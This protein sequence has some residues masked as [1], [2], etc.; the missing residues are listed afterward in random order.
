MRDCDVLVVGGGGAGMAA[1]IEA[2]D[3]GASVIVL[4]AGRRPGGSTALSGGVF[5]A[6][7]T[8]IQRAAGIHDTVEA[9]YRYYMTF[10]R[11]NLEPWLIRRF[12]EESAPT[13]EWLIGLGADIPVEGLYISGVED[14]P[15]GHH[16]RGSG[17]ALFERLMGAASARGVEIHA[18]IRV[19]GLLAADGVVEGITAQ[20]AELRAGAIVLAT[21]G[22]GANRALLA[23]FNPDVA[24]QDERWSFYFGS[25]TSR[26]DGIA[27][28]RALGAEVVGRDRLLVN[29]SPGFS[30]D[31]ADFHPPWL[32]FVNRDGQRF[33]DETWPY[34]IAGHRIEEQPGRRCFAIL[35]EPTRAA[36]PARH[37]FADKL[38][39]G[40]FAYSCD[41][42]AEEAAKGRILRAD[43][44]EELAGKA[45]VDPLGLAG[46]VARYNA[47]VRA[48]GDGQY[49]K[50]GPLTTIETAPFYAIEVHA[51][52]FGATSAGVRIDP[53]ARV[54][55]AGGR[56]IAGLYAA[57]ETA[58][59]VLGERYVGGGN[60]I[61]NALIFG[62]IAGRAAAAFAAQPS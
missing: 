47:D 21:G 5:Y 10:N 28:A 42:L 55:G 6:A 59:G 40:D 53:D 24:A 34:C 2:A 56:A 37:P 33:M 3:A 19:D 35:D 4:E 38:G 23:E 52:S 44:L 9:M 49:G 48:G 51:A 31:V 32:V 41:R 58:G 13:L 29:A 20:G 11:W 30:R 15:R 1:A 50:Q 46:T 16:T 27:M 39:V 12:C 14:V 36:S 17:I 60:Y 22:Y 43:T 54:L 7:G 26:G 62:R 61:A 25:E 57:G 8:S 45:G 18:D